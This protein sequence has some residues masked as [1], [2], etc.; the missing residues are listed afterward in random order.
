[1]YTSFSILQRLKSFRHAARGVIALVSSQHNA[2]IHAIATLVVC[3][4]GLYFRFSVVEWC[5]I[6]LSIMAVWTSEA[7]NTAL[8]FIADVASPTFH[9]QIKKAKDIAAAAVLLAAVGS[10]I[11]G[12][13]IIGPYLL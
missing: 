5:C 11:I 4:T 2:W 1:M 8:E 10:V 6:I 9:P 13:L 7:L 12:V 3:I